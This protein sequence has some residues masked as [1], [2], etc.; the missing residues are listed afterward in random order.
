MMMIHNPW[1]VSQGDADAHRSDADLL[2]E[3]KGGMVRIYSARTGQ[4]ESAIST[5]M[6]AETWLGADEAIAQGFADDR[7]EP[8]NEMA[9]RFDLAEYEYKKVPDAWAHPPPPPRQ[10]VDY[11]DRIAALVARRNQL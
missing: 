2:D 11:K 4:P 10:R 1:M 8:L 7:S 3:V 9:A 6:D 5:I